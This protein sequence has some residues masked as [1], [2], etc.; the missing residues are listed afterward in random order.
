MPLGFN[1][2]VNKT[3]E[4]AWYEVDAISEEDAIV[5]QFKE[6]VLFLRRKGNLDIFDNLDGN[7]LYSVKEIK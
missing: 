6:R 2:L 7:Q 3:G 5:T 4:D 1:Y